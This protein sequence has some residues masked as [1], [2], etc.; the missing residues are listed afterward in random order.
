MTW[1]LAIAIF[2][3]VVGVALF[4]FMK[5]E[6]AFAL[7]LFGLLAILF[8]FCYGVAESVLKK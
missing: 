1:L 3:A 6:A 5:P 8:V 2:V 4:A 7:G